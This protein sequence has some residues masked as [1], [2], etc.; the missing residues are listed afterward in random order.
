MNAFAIS[1]LLITITCF[2]LTTFIFF[3]APRSLINRLM[4]WFNVF[5]GFWGLGTMLVGLA[6]TPDEA[7]WAWRLAHIG[8]FPLGMTFYHLSSVMSGISRKPSPR[9]AYLFAGISMLLMMG[10]AMSEV[11]LMFGSVYYSTANVLYAVVLL[12]W[13]Y[14]VIVGH[15]NLFQGYKKAKGLEQKQLQFVFYAMF[16][17]FVGGCS[18]WLP[19]FYVPLYPY[20]NFSIPIYALIVTYAI[21][22]HKLLDVN[23]II[24]KSLVYSVLIALI[25]ATYLA[26]VV[27]I[28]K[29]L[30]GVIGYHS[31]V[32]TVVAAFVIALGFTPVKNAI[33]RLVDRLFFGGSQEKL[34]EENER[35]RQ[36]VAQSERLKSVSVLAAGLAHEIK[37]PLTAIKTFTE[38]LP[39]RRHDDEFI[40]KFHRIVGA[41]VQKIHATVQ[42]LLTFAK[43][44][45]F[46]RERLAVADVAQDTLDLLSN[47]CLKRQVKV[48]A[49]LDPQVMVE[50]DRV[51]LKQLLLNLCLNSLE[52][53]EPGG[54]LRVSVAQQN[55]HGVLSVEDTGSGIAQKDL[56]HIFDPFFTTKEMGTGLGLA[57]V[58]GIVKDH[59]GRIKIKSEKGKGTMVT[60]EFPLCKA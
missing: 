60:I 50:G 40:E 26:V 14:I 18:T 4:G 34:A 39:E 12:I 55:G 9:I 31:I 17:G 19:M 56:P 25:T 41:E 42:N 29:L 21:V 38:F 8:G 48:E 33:Q 49:A 7:L 15:V 44:D 52:A 47:D 36:E 22:R 32:G 5:V 53:M 57:V 58:H 6:R 10:P 20:G 13:V 23:F 3:R 16:I 24:R 54:E 51:K 46:K 59:H 45:G 37:N 11:H 28:E 1:G 43:A 27:L 2:S 35:L 30:Q